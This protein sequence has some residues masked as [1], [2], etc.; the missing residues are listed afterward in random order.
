MYESLP[1]LLVPRTFAESVVLVVMS[2]LVDLLNV[3]AI[4]GADDLYGAGR[5]LWVLYAGAVLIV[6]RRPNSTRER[7]E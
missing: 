5:W 2:Y 4:Y 1:L 3:A 7:E 6:L